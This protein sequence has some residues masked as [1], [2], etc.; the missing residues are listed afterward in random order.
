MSTLYLQGP[1]KQSLVTFAEPLE[2]PRT[3]QWRCLVQHLLE[4]HY[5]EQQLVIHLKI[6]KIHAN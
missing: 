6:K 3:E 5:H 2:T 4:L 1:F